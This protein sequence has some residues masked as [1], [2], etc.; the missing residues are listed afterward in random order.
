MPL[1]TQ[2]VLIDELIP[3]EKNAKIHDKK[4]IQQI[5]NSLLD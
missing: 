1:K 3:Y 2:D 5:A 4:Q